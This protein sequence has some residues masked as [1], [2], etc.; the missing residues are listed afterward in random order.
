MSKI[1]TPSDL[2]F[3]NKN[4]ISVEN[5]KFHQKSFQKVVILGK[6]LELS[7]SKNRNFRQIIEI[8]SKNR[9]F[10]KDLNFW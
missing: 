2:F 1:R 4:V 10:V 8:W 3:V 6:K 7:S 9:N 5:S